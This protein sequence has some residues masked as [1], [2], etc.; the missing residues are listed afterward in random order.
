MRV[1][2]KDYTMSELCTTFRY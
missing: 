2:G 1:I